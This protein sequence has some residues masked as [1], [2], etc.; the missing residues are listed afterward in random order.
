VVDVATWARAA[1]GPVSVGMTPFCAGLARDPAAFG[2]G[3]GGRDEVR[4]H[5]RLGFPDNEV[6]QAFARMDFA[7]ADD[8][9][10]ANRRQPAAEEAAR[11]LLEALRALQ[12]TAW[13]AEVAVDVRCLLLGGSLPIAIPGGRRDSS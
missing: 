12:G 6:G 5:V 8:G 10:V 2:I 1:F 3:P 11:P 7:E 4:V 9:R 13:A